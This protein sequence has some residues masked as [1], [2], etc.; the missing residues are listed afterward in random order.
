[1][2]YFPLFLKLAGQP[3]LIVGGGEVAARK[4]GLLL[5]AGAALTVIA[6]ELHPTLAEWS[7][8]GRLSALRRAYR[9]GD[10]RG[11]RLVIAATGDRR[12][13]EAV[14]SACEAANI[15]VNVADAR[16]QSRFIVPSIIDRSPLML[17]VSTAGRTPMLARLLRARI[18]AWLPHGYGGLAD[19]AGR[20]RG[21]VGR[22]F[23]NDPTAR[24]RFWQRVLEGPAAERALAGDVAGAEE[25]L[26]SEL[27]S[28][29][30]ESSIR[31]AVYLVGAG[32]GNP[33]LLTFRALRLMQ[34]A[35]AVLYDNLVSPEIVALARREAERIY[36]GKKA[37]KHPLPQQKI[38]RLMIELAQAG[39]A[40]LRLKG[41]DPFIFGRGGEEIEELAEAGIPFQVVPGITAA[42]G[43]S[44]YAGIPLTHRDHAQSVTFVTGHRRDGQVDLDWPRLTSDTETLVIYMGV[45]QAETICRQLIAHGRAPETPAAIVERAT[46]DRQR[47]VV[48]TLGNLPRLMEEASIEPPALIIIGS[49]VSLHEK[50]EWRTS[51]IR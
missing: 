26:R 18:E 40:V 25:I 16:E 34:Q 44:C 38:N 51:L 47:T 30:P 46:T 11:R 19:L 48:G 5:D 29:E 24:R 4:A 17:A 22:R 31:G 42:A 2:D 23:P 28:R 1:M 37:D 6:E 20:L 45:Q 3:C 33:D 7:E 12:V 21:A 10:E 8:A 14:F 35:D 32:P 9:P 15:L 41:G 49:V 36:V 43:A 27:A 39:K 13:N 50:L